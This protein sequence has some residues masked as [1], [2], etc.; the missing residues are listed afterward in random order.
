MMM[1]MIQDMATEGRLTKLQHHAR[2]AILPLSAL[3]CYAF[4]RKE[5]LGMFQMGHAKTMLDHY[6]CVRL[7]AFHDYLAAPTVNRTRLKLI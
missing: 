5:Y 4:H 1:M 2:G 7:I 3:G 6:M